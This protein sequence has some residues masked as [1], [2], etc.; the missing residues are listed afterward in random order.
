MERQLLA[1]RAVED[2]FARLFRQVT[3]GSI[4]TE[5]VFFRKRIKIHARDRVAAD[6]VPAGR[7][8]AAA[9]N[10]ERRVRHNELGIDA[11]LRAEAGAARAGA[12]RV[13]ERERAR[14]EL[15]DGDAAVLAGVV[16]RERE[17]A[18]LRG[19]ID[20]H[21]AA[22]ERGRGFDRIRQTAADIRLHYKTV[23]DDLNAVLFI[24]V[25]FNGFGKIVEIAVHTHAD[26]TALARVLKDLGVLALLAADDRGK[27][28][29]LRPLRQRRHLVNDLV[30]GLLADLLAAFGAVGGAAPG[31]QQAQ[32]I[33]YLRH[34]T[35][36][37]AGVPA[38][39]FLVDG[40]GG[41]KT[42]DIVHIR[43]FHLTE[44]HARVRRK[45]LHIPALSF[46]IDRVENERGFARAGNAGEYHELVARDLQRNIF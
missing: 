21:N 18:P 11:Q 16:L 34:R 8:D 1:A 26:I 4:K 31:I 24:L 15:F 12:V 33:M 2:H 41:R 30:N 19:E 29:E 40:N 6:I 42:V 7:Y 13:V 44:E 36:G 25:Q 38:G 10:G 32:V 22:R 43:L 35:H 14:R 5:M 17:F 23:H 37:G 46:G 28:L 39:A 45:A 27:D 20:R 3:D 9:E